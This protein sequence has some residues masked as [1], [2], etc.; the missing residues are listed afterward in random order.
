VSGFVSTGQDF[1]RDRSV[2]T[3][4][5]ISLWFEFDFQIVVIPFWQCFGSLYTIV[6]LHLGHNNQYNGIPG[7]CLNNADTI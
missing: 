6:F 3:N 7:S 5:C 4:T 1:D 2:V